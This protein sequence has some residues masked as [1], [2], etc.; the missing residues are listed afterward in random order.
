[1]DSVSSLSI[2]RAKRFMIKSSPSTHQSNSD[3]LKNAVALQDHY[4]R[5]LKFVG[6]P[7]ARPKKI[8]KPKRLAPIT[9]QQKRVLTEDMLDYKDV[10]TK[11][12]KGV[13]EITKEK[14]TQ[15]YSKYMH[16]LTLAQKRGLVEKPPMPL[17]PE[18][19]TE[20]VDKA[21]VR[22]SSN[23]SC[24]I[25][26]EFFGCGSQTILSCS[27]VFHTSCIKSLEKFCPDRKCPLCRIPNYD[28]S[29]FVEGTRI[30]IEFSAT[31]LQSLIR[32]R[33]EINRFMESLKNIPLEN[34]TSKRLRQSFTIY[35]M[36][37]ATQRITNLINQKNWAYKKTS[38]DIKLL[39]D[40]HENLMA[41]YESNVRKIISKRA[42]D[43]KLAL[44]IN[45]L[46]EKKIINGLLEKEAKQYRRW[47][48][49][50]KKVKDMAHDD[51]P[52]CLSELGDE[53]KVCITSCAHL[54]H[55]ACLKSLEDHSGMN[56]CPICRAQYERIYIWRLRD[57]LK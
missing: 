6:L 8:S 43:H 28:K 29:K 55:G 38:E 13:E 22:L 45:E 16:N 2:Q 1:M 41:A 49:R 5:Q 21:K 18:Q 47:Q 37:R 44:L 54:F 23:P 48:Q 26:M 51:C 10:I 39:Q 11:G 30:F 33:I 4:A 25:C 14:R 9:D 15:K 24:P 34:I 53:N 36:D 50:L 46:T 12:Y 20:I 3:T 40:D 27:H 17:T 19:W 57:K 42:E 7:G 56:K 52:I 35:K 32:M 31:K